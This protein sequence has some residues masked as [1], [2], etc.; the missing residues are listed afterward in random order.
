M[1]EW[2]GTS[3]QVRVQPECAASWWCPNGRGE[4]VQSQVPKKQQGNGRGEGGTGPTCAF[5]RGRGAVVRA[6][7]LCPLSDL[8]WQAGRTLPH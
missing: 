4:G 1:G 8:A 2:E 6:P 3:P 5:L 7:Q